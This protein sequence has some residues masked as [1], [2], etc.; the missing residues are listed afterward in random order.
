MGKGNSFLINQAI[1]CVTAGRSKT[2][3][4]LKP[5]GANGIEIV[6]AKLIVVSHPLLKIR[7]DKGKARGKSKTPIYRK[8]VTPQTEAANEPR[9]LQ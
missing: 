8:K 3:S 6:R 4:K 5:Y 2:W 9:V 7:L 1:I